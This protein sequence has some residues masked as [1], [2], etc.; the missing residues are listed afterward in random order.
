MRRHY[1]DLCQGALRV[2]LDEDGT[3][4]HSETPHPVNRMS[5]LRE[6]R[7]RLDRLQRQETVCKRFLKAAKAGRW[8]GRDH[9]L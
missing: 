7:S 9:K 1:I 6:V 4:G 3:V 8:Q 2:W 5:V